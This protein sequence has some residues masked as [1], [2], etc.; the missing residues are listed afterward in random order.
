MSLEANA[1]AGKLEGRGRRH[2]SQSPAVVSHVT[3]S[4]TVTAVTLVVSSHES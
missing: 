3:P 2:R 4:V 1:A